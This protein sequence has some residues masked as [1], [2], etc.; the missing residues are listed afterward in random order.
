MIFGLHYLDLLVVGIFIVGVLALGFWASRSVKGESDFFVAGRKM[1]PWL[2]FF[3]NFGQMSDSSSAPIMASEVYREGIGGIWIGFQLL[4]MSPF[5]WFSATWF[6][7]SRNVTLADLFVD[8]FGSRKLAGGYSLVCII[9][10]ILSIGLGNVVSFK[11]VSALVVKPE[12]EWTASERQSVDDFHAYQILK[13]AADSGSLLPQG[14]ERYEVL[15]SEEARSQLT[16]F[17][18]YI[19][20]V[21]FYIAYTAIVA[22]Y[23]ALGGIKAAAFTDAIQGVLIAIFSV[24]LI[25]LGLVRIGG[26]RGLHSLVDPAKFDLF[27]SASASDYTWYSV[28]AIVLF[29]LS[30]LAGMTP[31]PVSASARDEHAARIGALSGA[32]AKRLLTLAWAFCGL[33]AIAVLGGGLADPD[34]AWGSL[35]SV[36]LSPGFLGLMLSGMLLGHMPSVGVAAMNLSA[37]FVRSLYRPLITGRSDAHYLGVAKITVFVVLSLGVLTALLFTGVVQ[38][39]FTMWLFGAVFGATFGL[40]YFWRRLSVR[41]IAVTWIVWSLVMGVVPGVVPAVA[42]LRQCDALLQETQPTSWRGETTPPKESPPHSAGQSS[43]ASMEPKALFFDSIARVELLN[44]HS[45]SEGIGRFNVENYLLYCLGLPLQ[46]FDSAGLL[47]S[48]WLFDTIVPFLLLMVF[49]YF[50]PDTDPKTRLRQA[51]FFSKMKTPVDAS[52]E[53][54]ERQ[55]A[56]SFQQVDRF[57]HL[58]LFPVSAWEFTKWSRHDVVGFSLCWC[59][60]LLV[61]GLLWGML[62]L[63]T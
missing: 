44:P 40:L 24:M 16:S 58:K 18:S 63:G 17:V 41:A 27:S 4:L 47:T 50:L 61:V 62:S 13:K 45:K 25:P 3:L 57:D 1:G 31:G 22:S 21:S 8:R 48:R 15:S 9:L 29:G 19:H 38:M 12:S 5:Y 10:S 26:F 53:E 55:V 30:G 52:P 43:N 54:D 32:F 60:V 49:S 37:L 6:R 23:V 34:A 7:R 39:L 59:V 42:S 35:S 33:L 28:G 14:K 46:K 20:P 2:Q 56:L 51:R 11:V 36:L